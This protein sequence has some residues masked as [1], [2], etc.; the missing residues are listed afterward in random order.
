MSAGHA[1]KSHVLLWTFAPF[2]AL[3]VYVLSWPP[4]EMMNTTTPLPNPLVSLDWVRRA[5]PWVD[6]LYSPLQRLRDLG[7]EHGERNLL[8]R[9]YYWWS[10]KVP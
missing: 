7:E 3:A 9:Y 4:I 5:P 8:A 2:V 1:G 6:T 10:D